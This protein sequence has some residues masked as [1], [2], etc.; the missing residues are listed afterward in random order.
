M[1][2]YNIPS[3][4]EFSSEW[5]VGVYLEDNVEHLCKSCPGLN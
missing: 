1:L 2:E 5:S 3:L 4:G